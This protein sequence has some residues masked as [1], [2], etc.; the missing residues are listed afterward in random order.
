[1]AKRFAKLSSFEFP[2]DRLLAVL[3]SPDFQV[4]REKNNG[5]VEARVVEIERSPAKLVF[6][7]HTTEYAKGITGVDKTKTE[8]AVSRYE[9]DLPKMEGRWTYKGAHADKVVVWGQIKVGAAGKA[10]SMDADFNVEVK[11]PLIGGKIESAVA[12]E[13][14]KTW[15][16]YEN[17]IREFAGK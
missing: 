4:A 11:V 17:L 6:E 12:T 10:S 7:V 5:A 2:A 1:M 9:Y 8:K 14:E 3:T 13:A 15:P 16:S